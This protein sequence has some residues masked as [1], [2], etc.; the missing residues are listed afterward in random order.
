MNSLTI[1]SKG[2]EM[3]IRFN[4]STFDKGY[5]LSL[6]KRLE[7]ES[8]VQSAEFSTDIMK[9]ADDIENNWW[10]KNKAKFFERGFEIM[11]YN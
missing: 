6:I 3:L 7:I 2:D 1:E 10:E 11:N 8:T 4:R 5:L 9:I